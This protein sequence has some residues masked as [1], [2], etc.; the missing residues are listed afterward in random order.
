[1]IKY[2][3]FA[4]LFSSSLALAQDV[5]SLDPT[6]VYNTGNI[7]NNGTTPNNTSTNWQNVGSINQGLPC[8]SPEDGYNGAYCGPKP[9][10]NNGSFNFSYGVTDVYQLASIA[11][12]LPNSGTGL[13]VNGYN[14]GFTAKNGNGWDGAGLD[15]LS[16]YVQF[17]DNKGTQVVKDD[18]NLNYLFD[19]SQFYFSKNFDT[20]YLS[21]EL[22]TVR[23]GF[24]GG[25]TSNFW[26]GPYGPEITNISFSLKY[27][28]DPC[29]INPL[30]SATCPGFN[31]ALEK[32]MVDTPVEAAPIQVIT[33]ESTVEPTS[34]T[35]TQTVAQSTIQ[36]P[37]QSAQNVSQQ[38]SQSTAGPSLGSVLSMIQNNQAREN[39]IA[40]T[41]VSQANQVAQQAVQQAE[42]TA[43][44]TAMNS[45]SQS[46][47]MSKES[48]TNENKDIKINNSSLPLSSPVINSISINPSINQNQSSMVVQSSNMPSI[49]N[50]AQQQNSVGSI[51]SLSNYTA[52]PQQNVNNTIQQNITNT[53][54]SNS[55]PLS[56]RS[57]ISLIP[58]PVQVTQETP[59]QQPSFIANTVNNS[60][61]IDTPSLAS[62][63]FT[64]RGDPLQDYVEKNTIMVASIQTE[65][66]NQSVRS[67]VQDNDL[68]NGVK[69]ERMAST[70]TG[71]NLYLNM[72]LA[73]GSFYES[74][75]IYKNVTIK[76]NV[77]TMYFIEKGNTD[78]YNK[79]IDMQ[80]K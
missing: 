74:K 78:T 31:D 28:V 8:W 11:N 27:S 48:Y 60:I 2:I 39:A 49:N 33:A 17:Y 77:R 55:T 73:D 76:D 52:Q 45:S 67:N 10:F 9:Y 34:S 13:R 65:T 43:I 51:N 56:F 71:Y 50:V 63:L 24:V 35:N 25:D 41:A 40:Q 75:E 68:A 26:A 79:M 12:A 47:E 66:K 18:Y 53:N 64:K 44:S 7:V 19:W 37:T 72:L 42:Q 57:E 16:A 14:F 15:T 54:V 4:L 62:S 29:Y 36:E 1:M 69:I 3:A 59:P 21:N 61:S 80:Y 30:S 38:T 22:S 32:I 6:Q 58:Q 5:N 70:P 20:P 23:Y 46:V